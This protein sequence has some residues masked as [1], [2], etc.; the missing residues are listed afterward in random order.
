MTSVKGYRSDLLICFTS[1]KAVIVTLRMRG[2]FLLG[3]LGCLASICH[4]ILMSLSN[5]V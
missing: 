5:G 3:E 1:R 2:E 4:L